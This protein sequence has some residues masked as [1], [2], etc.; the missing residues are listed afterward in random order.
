MLPPKYFPNKLMSLFFHLV[1][2]PL[3]TTSCLTTSHARRCLY[4]PSWTQTPTNRKNLRLMPVSFCFTNT[5]NIIDYRI[6][7]NYI[8]NRKRKRKRQINSN[9][10]ESNDDASLCSHAIYFIGRCLGI[11][12]NGGHNNIV[13]SY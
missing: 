10:D 11:V 8:N 9:H 13:G 2:Y 1:E 3:P 7:Y 12:R 5:T 6:A 4:Y